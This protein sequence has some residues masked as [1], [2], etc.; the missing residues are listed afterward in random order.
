[1]KAKEQVME[2][3]END[4]SEYDDIKRALLGRQVITFASAAEAFFSAVNRDLL[5]EHLQQVGDKMIILLE[6]ITEGVEKDRA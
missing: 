4:D 1:M 5:N 2:Q 3:L 6:K